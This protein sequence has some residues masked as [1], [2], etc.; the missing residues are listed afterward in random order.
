[1][2]KNQLV[3]SKM[4]RIWWI[5]IWEL[6]SLK[7]LHFDWSLLRKAYKVWLKKYRGVIFH[8]A[9]KSRAKFEE[10][11]TWGLKND[12]RNLA[13]FHQN[14]WKCQNWGFIG[15]LLSKVENA[16]DKNLQRSFVSWEW[17]MMQNLKSNWLN[18]LVSSKFDMRNL[19]NFDPST[20]KSQKFVL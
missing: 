19:T 15:I 11:L 18:W 20:R 16:W 7:N 12:T 2:K 1:M 9:L 8:D 4:T 14:S 17:R 6:K 10:K 5:L 3:V 13:N